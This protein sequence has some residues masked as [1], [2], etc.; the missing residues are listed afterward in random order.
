ML[1][2]LIAFGVFILAVGFAFL[3]ESKKGKRTNEHTN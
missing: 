3:S 1:Y 2:L